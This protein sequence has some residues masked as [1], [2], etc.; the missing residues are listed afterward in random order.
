MT[1]ADVYEGFILALAL[2]ALA[3]FFDWLDRKWP[4]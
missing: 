4:G 3:R 1:W 2:F